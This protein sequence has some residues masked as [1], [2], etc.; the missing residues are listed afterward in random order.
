MDWDDIWNKGTSWL[1]KNK[2]AIGV[3][4]QIAN[5][6]LAVKALEDAGDDAQEFIGMP[7]GQSLYD[8]VAGDTRFKPFTVSSVPGTMTTTAAGD[9]TFALSPEQQAIEQISEN[10]RLNLNGCGAWSRSVRDYQSS[11][12]TP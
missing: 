8:T 11:D 3:A 6:E 7:A 5:Q 9:T 4:G 12:R 1:N 2:T 10:W